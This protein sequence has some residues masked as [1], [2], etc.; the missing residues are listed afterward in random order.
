MSGGDNGHTEI[1][2]E[3]KWPPPQ[4]KE[5]LEESS[6]SE[7]TGGTSNPGGT[8]R[9]Y[10]Q[11]DRGKVDARRLHCEAGDID[12]ANTTRLGTGEIARGK[13]TEQEKNNN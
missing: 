10:L 9:P 13:K 6:K 3:A 11:E 1:P 8:D 2:Q 5:M 12:R 4:D 7:Q